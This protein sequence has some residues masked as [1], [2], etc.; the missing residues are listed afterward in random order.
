LAKIA[1]N[2]DHNI[3]PRL[4]EFSPVSQ[5]FIFAL[6]KKLR[7]NFVATFFHGKNCVLILTKNGLGYIW[8]DFSQT[9]LVTLLGDDIWSN[10]ISTYEMT[11]GQT[12]NAAR[13]AMY[14]NLQQSNRHCTYLETYIN[15]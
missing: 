13:Q 7:P 8:G 2:C 14:V 11:S 6:F 15:T 3:D 10:G 12:N 4:G 1:E 5:L 9:H